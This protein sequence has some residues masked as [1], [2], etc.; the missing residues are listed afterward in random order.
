MNKKFFSIILLITVCG[1][2]LFYVSKN[3]IKV[4]DIIENSELK[5]QGFSVPVV[6]IISPKHGIKAYLLEDNTNPIISM[7]FLF[8]QAGYALDD[9]GQEGISKLTA[10]IIAEAAGEFDSQEF[11]EILEDHAISINYKVDVDDF[12]GSLLTTKQFSSL[13]FDLLKQTLLKTRIDYKDLKRI[14]K[15]IYALLKAQTENPNQQLSL[16]AN[17][18]LFP[19][20]PY[21]K[22]PLGKKQDI[23]KISS[24]DIKKFITSKLGQNNLIVGIAGDITVDEAQKMLDE[25]F[26]SLP[27][28][29][30]NNEIQPV[31]PYLASG[32]VHN[33]QN[34]PQN[35]AF[36]GANAAKRLSKDFYP[37]YIANHIL[38]GSG[39]NSR[40]NQA[41]RA[42]EGLTYGIYTGLYIPTKTSMIIG[43]FSTTA[44]NFN[45]VEEILIDQW[46]KLGKEG[47][48]SEELN[49]AKN[50]LLNSYNL[51]FADITNISEMLVYMQKENL[52]IDFLQKR[53]TYISDVT[54]E[55]VN[56][57]AAKYFNSQN[58]RLISIG[59][60]N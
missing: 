34:L 55:Q 17:K 50:Y 52:G 41:A 54:L 33:N 10:A 31:S 49:I 1:I 44:E 32:F 13:A 48:S 28:V 7:N 22:N 45:R 8:T 18:E 5:H 25:I 9:N 57:A 36:I 21:G 6:E 30:T 58:L 20:H 59:K 24:G 47:V 16:L 27:I 15:Q 35:I 60:F 40:L 11:K 46:C 51:R 12:S 19:N 42:K 39:L 56:Q 53:N 14:K 26:G 23:K 4:E 43:G 3:K 29:D 37:L 38:G 2:S